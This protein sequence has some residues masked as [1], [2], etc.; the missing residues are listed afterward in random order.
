M[1]QR[2][3]TLAIIVGSLCGL[4][5]LTW[6]IPKIK[7]Q[8]TSRNDR[9]EALDTELAKKRAAKRQLGK[10]QIVLKKLKEQSLCQDPDLAQTQYKSW[11]IN[12]VKEDVA[13]A[14]VVVGSGA[15]QKSGDTYVQHS[16]KVTGKGDLTQLT[17][18]LFSFYEANYLHR[19]RQLSITPLPREGKLLQFTFAI[20]AVSLQS[21]APEKKLSTVKT[22][23]LAGKDINHFL[24]LIPQRNIF[25][26]GNEYAPRFSTRDRTETLSVEKTEFPVTMAFK[27]AASDKDGIAS[28][29]IVKHTL[30]EDEATIKWDPA[31]N[32]TIVAKKTG[33]YTL[34]VR[35]TDKGAPAKTSEV[36]AYTVRIREKDPPRA[37]TPEPPKFDFA[38][39]AFFIASVE[40]GGQPEA[41]VKRRES[42]ETLKLHVGDTVAIGSIKGKIVRITLNE[43]ELAEGNERLVIQTGKS[44]ST[45]T[46][47]VQKS[48]SE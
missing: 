15:V 42:G 20:D 40:V 41:W 37:P 25:G 3:K 14:D 1:N 28:Y 10:N 9:I 36:V 34:Q 22:D 6:S 7:N 47:V 27:L 31:G 26:A 12:A 33:E 5:L 13:F 43:L 21:V 30:P 48:G 17:K 11:L 39:T 18:F 46:F 16:F 32:V 19:I 2:E 44:L 38:N 29:E 45:A 23:T 24:D 4:F 35:A 8:L